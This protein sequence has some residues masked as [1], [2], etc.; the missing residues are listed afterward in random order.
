MVDF[1][2]SQWEEIGNG[3][4]INSIRLRVAQKDAKSKTAFA[5]MVLMFFYKKEELKGKRLHELDQDIL[6]TIAGWYLR[7]PYILVLLK[8]VFIMSHYKNFR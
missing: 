8:M 6:H 4:W 7:Y 2:S 5:R 1:L 3:V